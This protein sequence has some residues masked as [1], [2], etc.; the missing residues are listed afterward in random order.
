MSWV[1]TELQEQPAALERLLAAE[2][3][4]ATEVAR[5]LIREDVRY[6]LI[7]SRGSS[8]NVA[9]Y[10]Q[11]LFGAVNRLPVAFATPSL[12]SVYDSAPE[13]GPAAAIGISQSGASPDVVAVLV[14]ARRQGRPTLAITNDPRSPL[15]QAADWTLPLH[16]G[17]ERAVAAT[18][19]YLNSIAAVAL[20]SAA[21]VGD[22]SR[23]AE[24]H[25]MPAVVAEQIDRSIAGAEALDRYR[26]VQSGSVIARGVNYGTAFEIALKIRELS[27]APFEAFSSA[28]LLHG[29]IAALRSGRPAIVIAP[30][31]KTLASLRAAVDKVRERG[32]E[33]IAISDDEEFLAAADTAFPL[34]RTVPEWLTPLLTVIPGQVAAVRLARLQGADVD[35][36]VGLTKITLTR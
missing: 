14:E 19:T 6:L 16:A 18:K 17:E 32:A 27:G 11:Y 26:D 22:S 1:D 9:R 33:V 4:H 36:P 20:L 23:L 10:M 15:A 5:G 13:L 12:Y 35:K 31:G 24:L 30:S 28:D 29:P 3:A 2:S 25:S 34:V 8:S 7:V 21:A